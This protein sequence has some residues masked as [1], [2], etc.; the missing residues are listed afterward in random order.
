ME[1][2]YS[3]QRCKEILHKEACNNAPA[4]IVEIV[5][6]TYPDIRKTLNLLQSCIVWD[7]SGKFLKLNKDIVNQKQYTDQ[8]LKLVKLNDSTALSDIRQI[9]ADSNVRDYH[10]LYRALFDNLD[11]FHNPI[12]GTVII[13]ESQYQSVMAPDKEINF[14]GCIANLLK[15]F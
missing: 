8:I 15:P 6:K 4:D 5:N 14:M 1:T 12:L 7:P 9:I 11:S 13:A 2:K 10:E 3:N